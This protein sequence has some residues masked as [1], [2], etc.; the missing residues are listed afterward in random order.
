MRLLPALLLL[1][2]IHTSHAQTW[3]EQMLDPATDLHTV[4]QS[5]DQAWEGRSYQKGKGW[6]QFHR[7]YWF[8]DQRTWPSGERLDP[9]VH[10]EAAAEVNAARDRASGQRDVSLWEPLGPTFWN[11]ISY[12]PGN[13]RVNAV[14]VDPTN[15][16]VVYAGTPAAGL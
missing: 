16:Q 5:F 13:G 1:L 9:A 6:K 3:V 2:T 15:D 11:S 12:N 8:M 10:M 4:K 7:W 14:A